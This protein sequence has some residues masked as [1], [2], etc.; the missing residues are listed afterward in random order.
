MLRKLLIFAAGDRRQD[1]L[2]FSGNG[3]NEPVL[4]GKFKK[5]K[6]DSEMGS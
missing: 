3:Q 4:L 5:K 6:I 1:L 2:A